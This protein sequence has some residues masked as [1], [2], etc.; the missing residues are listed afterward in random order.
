M[1]NKEAQLGNAD[2]PNVTARKCAAIILAAGASRRLGE[3]KQ[4]LR[5][6]GQSLLSRTARLASEAGLDPVY[7]IL[8]ASSAESAR[9]IAG[10]QA[11]AIYNPSWQNGMGCSLRCGV[12]QILGLQPIPENLAVLVCDQPLLSAGYLARLLQAHIDAGSK[13]TSSQYGGICGVPAVFSS[14]IFR[15]L[16]RIPGDRGARGIIEAYASER[17][18]LDFPEGSIDI[19]T[20][21]DVAR[22]PHSLQVP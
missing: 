2:R 9:E 21:A 19:D 22:L 16:T 4:L 5:Y 11:R 1:K 17:T 14:Q 18:V 6:E 7:V 13:L 3:P 8:G 12:Q 10:S 15:E 20:P